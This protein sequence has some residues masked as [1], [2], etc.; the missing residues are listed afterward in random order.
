VSKGHT[1]DV[2]SICGEVVHAVFGLESSENRMDDLLP[3]PVRSTNMSGWHDMVSIHSQ[4]KRYRSVPE[5]YSY[6]IRLEAGVQL[7]RPR[8]LSV[9]TA[10]YTEH[11]LPCCLLECTYYL[12]GR[13]LG[14]PQSASRGY[15]SS[16]GNLA[17]AV[18]PLS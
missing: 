8:P 1:R 12:A 15:L 4:H 7:G 13:L 9:P 14:T 2:V 3:L 16:L 5:W 10:T 17:L 18:S 6:H 11:I